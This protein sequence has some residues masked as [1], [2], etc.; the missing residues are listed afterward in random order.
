M[1]EDEDAELILQVGLQ[2]DRSTMGIAMIISVGGTVE[3]IAFSIKHHRPEFVCFLASQDTYDIA[4]K[5][6]DTL[7]TEG[8]A[9]DSYL[10]IVDDPNDLMHCYEKAGECAAICTGKGYA[11]DGIIVDYTGGTKN[12]T[13]AVSLAS[14]EKGFRFSYV[15]G[16]ERTKDGKGIVVTGTEE[17]R[18]AFGP[19]SFYAMRE[20]RRLSLYFNTYQWDAALH[21]LKNL[22][23][24][25]REEE[26]KLFELFSHLTTGYQA[27]DCF[28]QGQALEY[29]TKSLRGFT[30]LLPFIKDAWFESFLSGVEGNR[31]FL[32]GLKISSSNFRKYVAPLACDLFANAGRRYEEG[33]YDDAV[34]RLYRVIEFMG[35]IRVQENWNC[36]TDKV[37]V[38]ILPDSLKKEY[39][40]RYS[41]P[42]S[43]EYV[44]LPL[45]ATFTFLHESGD[46][47]G[48]WFVANHDEIKKIQNARNSSIL[49]HGLDPIRKETYEKFHEILR[50]KIDESCV[51][52]FPKLGW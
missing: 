41:P 26:K 19:E 17:A 47:L 2:T 38:T 51:M 10:A 21:A 11:E 35:Q 3:P 22:S 23:P 20:K 15:S 37:P 6:R 33:K 48:R 39:T 31:S 1:A 13:A 14:F 9:F 32:E 12:M 24:A 44:K 8:I 34:A 4:I 28:R 43:R 16:K 50:E 42:N 45:E 18:L 5:A 36:S 52:R 40:E 27:W 49:A 46:E 7:K 30:T 29:I 25:A